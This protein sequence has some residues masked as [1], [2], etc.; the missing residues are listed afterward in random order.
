MA[1]VVAGIVAF[2]SL[3]IDRYPKTDLP[4]V[5]VRTAYPGAASEEVESEV[6]KVLEDAVATVAGIEELRS[7][8]QDG[9]SLVLVT[10]ALT[11]DID[12]AVQDIRDAVSAAIRQLP[13]NIDPPVVSKSDLDSSPIMTIAVSG[14]RSSLELYFLA[15]R[16]VKSVIESSKGVGQ[17]SISGAAE[18]A[19]KINVEAQRLAAYQLSIMQVRDAIVQQN[20]EVPGGRVDEGLRERALRTMG[21]VPESKD[22]SDLVVDTV[23]GVPIRLRDLGTIEDATKEV[24]SISRLNGVP[25]VTLSVQRQA[26]ENTVEVIE[27]VKQRLDRARALLPSDIELTVIQDQSRYILAALHEIENHLVSGSIL[28]CLTVLLFMRSWRSTLIASV[29][30]PASIIATFAFM[31]AFDFTLNNVTMLAL[32][33]MVGVVI[34]DAIVV[35]ENIF[36]CIEEE[37]MDPKEASIKG[38]KEIG[39]A[40]L[41]TTVSLVIVFLPV[42]FLSSVTGRMLFQFGITA[43]VAI[44]VSMFI[45]FT[46]T[47]MMCSLLLKKPKSPGQHGA[48]SRSGLYGWIEAGYMFSLRLAMKYRF[49]TLILCFLTIAA[50]IP[51]YSWVQQDYIPTNVDESE[52]EVSINAKE[53]TTIV[54]MNTAMAKVEERL[55]SVDGVLFTLASV[56]T[57]GFG[58][59]NSGS[60]Y[61]RLV[62]SE[63]RSFSVY[64]FAKELWNGTPS[65]AFEGNYTQ[66]QKMAEIRGLLKSFTDVRV[67]IRNL[68]SLRQGAN[69]DIDYSIVGPDAKTMAKFSEALRQKAKEIPGIVDVD[70]TLRLDKPEVLV[71]IDRERAA[72]LGVSVQEIA[73]TLRIAVGGD[74][75][76]SRY[77]DP[78]VDD[79][80]DVELRLVGVDR[81]DVDSISQ[82]Y[83]RA[84]PAVAALGASI[85]TGSVENN[86]SGNVLTRIENLVSFRYGD[87]SARIDRLDRQRMVAI[88]ANITQGYSLSDRIDAIHAEAKKIGIPAGFDTRVLGRGRELERTVEEFRWVLLLSFVFM[89]IVL[90][91]QFEH[92]AH[93]LTIL[94]TLPLS[95]PFGLISLWL[96]SESLNVYSA[97]GVLVLF[98]VVK[99]AAILQIDCTNVLRRKGMD[100]TAAILEA[101]RDRFRPILM[102]TISFVAGL[103]PLL[104]ATGPGAEE[105]RSIAVLATGGQTLSLLLTL[106]AVPVIYS[107]LDDLSLLFKRKTSDQESD[108]EETLAEP[109]EAPMPVKQPSVA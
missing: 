62:D 11:R 69:V 21:R 78:S 77:R 53:G 102:T 33:L 84:N 51:L 90:A 18:R 63:A 4:T 28:A 39:L 101:N 74:D 106:L 105:R 68:T 35:L 54:A 89:Y 79:A 14:N 29:A 2:P 80:Y 20:T 75:R 85:A 31:K 12:A 15:D 57:R 25:N 38:T 81:Q 47:P 23:G 1:L 46:L 13:R 34:D 76:V 5:F 56:G 65:K 61:V 96:G 16:Y 27:A 94:F 98:G 91:A 52:F 9:S 103:L 83:V 93:P 26:G 7:I 44:L 71:D 104:I 50:N 92:L 87:A 100:R 109:S 32:V 17:V 6:S 48:S 108:C 10:F 70:S 8:S 107:Y 3:G 73:D 82:L 60:I 88:R 37:G 41:A 40:V 19:V 42:S 43:T 59:V 64:R 99:K 36:R 72:S 66:Q 30:I 95:V 45:S 67:S 22:F 97:L 58:G 49:A 24:R 86:P 55:R